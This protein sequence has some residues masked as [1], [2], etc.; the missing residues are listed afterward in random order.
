MKQLL[1]VTGCF[2]K[3][4][5]EHYLENSINPYSLASNVLSWRII[6]GLDAINDVNLRVY[7][8]PFVPFFKK[9]VKKWLEILIKMLTN[10]L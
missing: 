4:K 3:G 5:E 1:F 6:D 9:G 7:S 8:C 10:Q 2:P